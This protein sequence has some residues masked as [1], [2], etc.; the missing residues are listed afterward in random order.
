MHTWKSLGPM[1][2]YL[3]CNV[4]KFKRYGHGS[5]ALMAPGKGR[6]QSDVLTIA[7][8]PITVRHVQNANGW[9]AHVDLYLGVYNS[10][11]LFTLP[12]S[13]NKI[14]EGQ[15]DPTP[16]FV[17]MARRALSEM[18]AREMPVSPQFRKL[19]TAGEKKVG[20]AVVESESE[21]DSA[22]TEFAEPA[23]CTRG[24]SSARLLH[25]VRTP[26]ERREGAEP[27]GAATPG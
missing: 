15:E 20:R 6:E 16:L 23:R 3:F 2:A 25:S 13:S 5:A 26:D 4:Q 14:Y 10:S 8:P 27:S 22:S 12:L 11:N 7:L 19:L 21:S 18:V 9:T 24:S 17:R 1:S